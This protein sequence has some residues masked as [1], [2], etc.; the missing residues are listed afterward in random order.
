MLL[1]KKWVLS[2]LTYLHYWSN[3]I[4]GYLKI[5]RNFNDSP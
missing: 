2:M 5:I 3:A 1:A 4:L